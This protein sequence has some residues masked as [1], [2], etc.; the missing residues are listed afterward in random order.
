MTGGCAR[1]IDVVGG[2][3]G[4]TY[5]TPTP[6]SFLRWCAGALVPCLHHHHPYHEPHMHVHTPT[7]VIRYASRFIS[8][9][10]VEA[11]A[12]SAGALAGSIQHEAQELR[13]WRRGEA[14]RWMGDE[15]RAAAGVLSSARTTCGV[16]VGSSPRLVV[17]FS[18]TQD[19]K[20]KA[21]WG[22]QVSFAGCTTP[23]L[24]WCVEGILR[25]TLDE[26]RRA[27]RG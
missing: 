26:W 9:R 2:A 19:A 18:G 24:A 16:G 20:C 15:R 22:A 21:H 25:A 27:M 3:S 11:Q 23:C 7:D 14:W 5:P 13:H 12:R 8:L 10:L 6:P 1:A 17:I 4:Y